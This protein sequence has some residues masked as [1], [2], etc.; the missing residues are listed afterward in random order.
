MLVSGLS[1]YGRLNYRLS[2]SSSMSLGYDVADQRQS[3]IGTA[4]GNGA[5]AWSTRLEVMREPGREE[6]PSSTPLK[7]LSLT[8]AIVS[9]WIQ[10][11]AEVSRG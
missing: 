11:T 2:N 1:I 7:G 9:S 3:S 4:S 6:G 8:S 10:P 5:G